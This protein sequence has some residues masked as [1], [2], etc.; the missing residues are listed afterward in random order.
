MH[1]MDAYRY[2]EVDNLQILELQYGDGSLSMVVL[3]PKAIDGLADLE[4]N[5]TYKKLQQW[6]GSLRPR[7]VKV[8][9]PKFKTSSQFKMN[10]TLKEMGMTSAFDAN[11]ADFSGMTGGRDLFI[12]AVVH[13]AFVDVNEEGT[14]AAA[15]TGVMME[16]TSGRIPSPPSVFRADHPFVFVIRDNRNKSML[17]MGRI[18]NPME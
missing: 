14:E 17:F 10:D 5:L 15:A 1:R 8:T 13:E 2:G 3:L 6:T 12:S 4:A 7:E 11:Q 18:Q 16:P 9:L